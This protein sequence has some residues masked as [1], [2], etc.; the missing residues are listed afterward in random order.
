M[1][2][3]F[4]Y[5]LLEFKRFTICLVKFPFFFLSQISSLYKTRS[6]FGLES[7]AICIIGGGEFSNET[8]Y[9]LNNSN[10]EIMALNR[11][12]LS[13]R[14]LNLIPKYYILIDPHFFNINNS[15]TINILNYIAFNNIILFIPFKVESSFKEFLINQKIR[16]Y[17]VETRFSRWLGF[18]SP[19]LPRSTSGMTILL[20]LNLALSL[21]RKK[22]YLLGFTS[23]IFSF[24][25]V[26]SDNTIV[27]KYPSFGGINH[28]VLQTDVASFF[29][30]QY[31]FFSDLKS[32]AKRSHDRVYVIGFSFIDA[33]QKL[34]SQGNKY[35]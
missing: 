33:F 20:A 7:K 22:I 30:A 9:A 8:L 21:S 6:L 12:A 27:L 5:Q 31:Y 24:L 14:S 23:D 17:G 28:K 29:L 3:L 2:P 15:E 16:H 34:E 25:S 26:N 13:H 1:S 4:K 35:E 10:I 32:V 11:Y 19:L 18:N